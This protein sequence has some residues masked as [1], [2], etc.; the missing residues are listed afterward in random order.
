MSVQQAAARFT[1]TV[2]AKFSGKRSYPAAFFL[3]MLCLSILAANVELTG[4]D[5]LP[6]MILALLALALGIQGLRPD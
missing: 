1:A 4:Q 2:M 3:V 6:A 5:G